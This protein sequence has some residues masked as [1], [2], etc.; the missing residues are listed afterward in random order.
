MGEEGADFKTTA[1]VL[2][3][4]LRAIQASWNY[5]TNFNEPQQK[6]SQQQFLV[7]IEKD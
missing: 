3:E 6:P 5:A 1:R 4:K 2:S 7:S